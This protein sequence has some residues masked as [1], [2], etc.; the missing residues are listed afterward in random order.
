[1]KMGFYGGLKLEFHS[2]KVTPN[3]GLIFKIEYCPRSVF[4][5]FLL[6]LVDIEYMAR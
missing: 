5:L 2:E 1:M 4:C 3:G 6:I